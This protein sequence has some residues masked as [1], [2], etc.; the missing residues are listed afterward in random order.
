MQDPDI[1]IAMFSIYSMYN[2]DEI[3]NLI[4][5]YYRGKCDDKTRIKIYC[6]VSACGLLWSNWCEFKRSFGIEFGDY[7][8]KQYRYAKDFYRIYIKETGDCA[9]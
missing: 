6:Y 4:D 3:D 7:A 5:V 1:D 8:L 2:K 9:V